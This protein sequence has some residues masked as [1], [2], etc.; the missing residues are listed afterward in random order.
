MRALVLKATGSEG[1]P[2]TPPVT[3]V[4][5]DDVWGYSRAFA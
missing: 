3:D 5:M 4:W 2:S 1:N